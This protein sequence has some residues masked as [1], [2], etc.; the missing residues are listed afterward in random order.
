MT[1]VRCA[2]LPGN[3]S[4][5]FR[6]DGAMKH[7]ILL[8]LMLCCAGYRSWAQPDL[9]MLVSEELALG[10]VVDEDPFPEL[11]RYDRLNP[12]VGGDSLRLCPGGPCSGWVEDRYADGALR[13]RGMYDEGRLVVYRNLFP[14]GTLERE[15]KQQDA[16]KSVMRTYHRNAKL[17]SETRFANGS[18]FEYR[19]YYMD[20]TLRYAE[21]RHRKE[22]YFLRMDL[23]SPRGEPIS[24]LS[25]VDRKRVEFELKEFYP[26]GHLRSEG[27]ARYDPRRMDSQR[28]G[29]WKYYA[30]DG[31][32][33]REED[34]VAGKVHAVR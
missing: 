6:V 1:A 4:G 17:R 13:H 33:E 2:F 16:I 9:T 12:Q 22:P 30:P 27:R 15:F 26:G 14:D 34:Y 19:D 5:A 31:S 28:I 11:S 29:T 32:V 3:P 8:V 21:E 25:L 18:A 10:V 23:F 7:A 20:G 24:L